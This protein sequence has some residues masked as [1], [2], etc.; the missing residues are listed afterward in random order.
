MI[1]AGSILKEALNKMQA[2]PKSSSVSRGGASAFSTGQSFTVCDCPKDQG[3]FSIHTLG[4]FNVNNIDTPHHCDNH[5]SPYRLLNARARRAGR[6]GGHHH[7][8]R[9]C[10]FLVGQNEDLGNGRKQ[11]L[12]W[13]RNCAS[14]KYHKGSKE[15]KEG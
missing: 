2:N 15:I 14:S 4:M 12:T 13:I 11:L 5:E 10:F 8:L 7:P 3:A 6:W 9:I 1:N